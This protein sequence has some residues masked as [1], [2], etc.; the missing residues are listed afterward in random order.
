MNETEE[1]TSCCG[2][3][4]KCDRPEGGCSLRETFSEIASLYKKPTENITDGTYSI[5]EMLEIAV[6]EMDREER[7]R[8]DCCAHPASCAKPPQ[9]CKLRSWYVKTY[10]DEIVSPSMEVELMSRFLKG[11]FDNAA[12]GSSTP[13]K[14]EEPTIDR[15]KGVRHLLGKGISRRGRELER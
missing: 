2:N 7:E 5:S 10:K 1:K 6:R 15:F 8:L 3:L 9:A 14:A 4:N 13:P 11:E 12:D